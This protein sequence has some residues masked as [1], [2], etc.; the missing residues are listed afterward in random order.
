MRRKGEKEKTKRQGAELIWT[1][2]EG[3][4]NIHPKR[5]PLIPADKV[6]SQTKEPSRPARFLSLSD[7]GA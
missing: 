3:Q 2:T 6:K 5:R 1:S 4:E 7:I